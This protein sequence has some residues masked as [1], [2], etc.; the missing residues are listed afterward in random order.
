MSVT[1]NVT[2]V[3]PLPRLRR[4]SKMLTCRHMCI[5]YVINNLLRMLLYWYW[6]YCRICGHSHIEIA[7]RRLTPEHQVVRREARH[8]MSRRVVRETHVADASIP[9]LVMFLCGSEKLNNRAIRA[10]ILSIRLRSIRRSSSS[11]NA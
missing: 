7:E 1:I 6:Q 10:L 4:L 2:V 3:I 8:Y 11:L 5:V 9:V